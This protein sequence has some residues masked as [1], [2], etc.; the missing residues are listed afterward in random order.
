MGLDPAADTPRRGL[1]MSHEIHDEGRRARAAEAGMS[2]TE[3]VV[4][5]AIVL[6]LAGFVMPRFFSLKE[7]AYNAMALSA[8]EDLA[9]AESSRFAI[10]GDYVSCSSV[11]HCGKEFPELRLNSDV[12]LHATADEGGFTAVAMH[13]SGNQKYVWDSREGGLMLADAGGAGGSGGGGSGDPSGDPPPA[14]DPP[15]P[16]PPGDPAPPPDPKPP[17]PPDPKP[18]PKPDPPADPDP[19][20]NPPGNGGGG[21]GNGGRGNGGRGGGDGGR[22]GGGGRGNSRR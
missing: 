14:P 19:P 6:V 8:L 12:V 3:L 18:D 13:P 16:D 2:V 22:G 20:K 4:G 21:Q 10:D 11:E 5:V 7:G 1:A 15:A 17:S 9:R